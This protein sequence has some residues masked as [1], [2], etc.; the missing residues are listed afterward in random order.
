VVSA[1][2]DGTAAGGA[3]STTEVASSPAGTDASPVEGLDAQQLADLVAVPS[4]STRA[5]AGP[6]VEV[7][8]SG[9]TTAWRV[10]VPGRTPVRAARVQV[11]VGG[12]VVGLGIPA[13]DLG[14]LTAVTLDGSGLVAG[15]PVALRWEGS[16]PQA[17]G[18]LAVVR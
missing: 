10:R 6:S 4:R 18:T 1:A 12:R 14:S 17:V 16:E 5:L 15:A 7:V 8:R 11:L 9:G 2:S 13:A 3:P